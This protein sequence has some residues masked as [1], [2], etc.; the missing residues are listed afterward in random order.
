MYTFVLNRLLVRELLNLFVATVTIHIYETNEI[1]DIK[2]K[3][4]KFE[5]PTLAT[6]VIY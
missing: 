2:R 4:A 5:Q 3:Q 6:P 1:S